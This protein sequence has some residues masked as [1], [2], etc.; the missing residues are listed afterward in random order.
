MATAHAVAHY[1]AQAAEAW[2]LGLEAAYSATIDA[3][4]DLPDEPDYEDA[5]NAVM[6]DGYELAW[7]LNNTLIADPV[8]PTDVLALACHGYDPQGK[9]ASELL[10]MVINA[11]APHT[12]KAAA[13]ELRQRLQ[14]ALAQRIDDVHGEA[15]SEWRDECDALLP[16]DDADEV[17]A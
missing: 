13:Y 15:M 9:S 4:V 2:E 3:G 16:D 8:G 1:Q 6:F 11:N 12:I 14:A 5:V 17:L 10:A 7:A